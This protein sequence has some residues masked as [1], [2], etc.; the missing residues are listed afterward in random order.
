MSLYD[1]IKQLYEEMSSSQGDYK[2]ATEIMLALIKKGVDKKF[3]A[4]AFKTIA[5]EKM[6]MVLYDEV[7]NQSTLAKK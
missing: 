6:A 5:V 4:E 1:L 7:K 2:K 3:I